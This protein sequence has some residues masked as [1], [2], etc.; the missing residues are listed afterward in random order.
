MPGQLSHLYTCGIKKKTANAGTS[1][2]TLGQDEHRLENRL[3][4]RLVFDRNR[5]IVSRIPHV[6][7]F[8]RF[9]LWLCERVA[10]GSLFQNN[11]CMA[12]LQSPSSFTLC[13]AAL[14]KHSSVG[15]LTMGSLVCP[16]LKSQKRGLKG[17]QWVDI[18][19]CQNVTLF[20]KPMRTQKAHPEDHRGYLMLSLSTNHSCLLFVNHLFKGLSQASALENWDG[21]VNAAKRRLLAQLPVR[22]WSSPAGWSQARQLGWS[23][24]RF[25]IGAV[26][27]LPSNMIIN[28]LLS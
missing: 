26:N 14:S 21:Y 1:L 6:F 3:E 15:S 8:P 12:E 5:E 4:N 27:L 16:V 23:S 2:A 22:Q 19:T 18:L 10:R 7:D 13:R 11:S 17:A 9:D 25:S 28:N 20:Q 24:L